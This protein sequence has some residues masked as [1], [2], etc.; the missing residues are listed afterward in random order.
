MC[1]WQRRTV[2]IQQLHFRS[3][4]RTARTPRARTAIWQ[5]PARFRAPL[6]RTKVQGTL[7]FSNLP[8][9]PS[10]LVLYIQ[11]SSATD[12]FYIDDVTIGQL[13]PAP[14]SPSQ[15]D[16]SGISTAFEDGGLDGWSSRTGSSTLTNTTAEAH[17]GS[18]SLLVTG[19]VANYDGPQIQMSATRCTSGRCTAPALRR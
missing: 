15:Q 14:P 11:S 18:H 2:A 16:N 6:A 5:R 9:P 7:S 10:S 4:T 13:S 19:R 3:R 8:G 12:S 17:S 1:C